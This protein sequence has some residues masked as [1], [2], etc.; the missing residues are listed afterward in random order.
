MDKI[1]KIRRFINRFTGGKVHSDTEDIFAEGLVN[2]LFITQLAVFIEME[3]DLELQKEDLEIKNI[4]SVD[5]IVSL[6]ETKKAGG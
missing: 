5:A 6:I 2:S 3:F 1:E 4:C